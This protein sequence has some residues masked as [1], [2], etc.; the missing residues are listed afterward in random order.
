M[1]KIVN[2]QNR[3]VPSAA[4]ILFEAYYSSL[5]NAKKYLIK[6][7]RTGESFV[8][9]ENNAVVGVLIYARDYSH[10]ANYI[11]D[12]AISKKYMKKGIAKKLLEKYCLADMG[13]S[14]FKYITQEV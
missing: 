2:T 11:E 10:Y 5:N 9:L 6:K 4:R 12:L 1:I 7:I 3:H 14:K 13:L 8:A